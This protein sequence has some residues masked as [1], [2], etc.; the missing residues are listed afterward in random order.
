MTSPGRIIWDGL[1]TDERWR[2][3]SDLEV[4][5]FSEFLA[6]SVLLTDA[7]IQR[8]SLSSAGIRHDCHLA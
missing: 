5:A 1:V 3:Y 8:Q 7:G 4:A 6:A 2:Q